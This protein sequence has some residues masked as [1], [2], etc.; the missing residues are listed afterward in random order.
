MKREYHTISHRDGENPVVSLRSGFSGWHTFLG[1][2][3]KLVIDRQGCNGNQRSWIDRDQQDQGRQYNRS[4]RSSGL[5]G[6]FGLCLFS[7]MET[8]GR[9][10]HPG[11]HVMGYWSLLTLWFD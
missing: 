4:F 1:K 11:K 5:E 8:C 6:I 9:N 2:N 10:L 3:G 7:S